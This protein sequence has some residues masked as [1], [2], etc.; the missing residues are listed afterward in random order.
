MEKSFIQ[1]FSW[2]RG[3]GRAQEIEELGPHPGY[4]SLARSLRIQSLCAPNLI[5]GC[6]AASSLRVPRSCSLEGQSLV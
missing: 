6:S 3:K 4:V 5:V 1:P 2:S